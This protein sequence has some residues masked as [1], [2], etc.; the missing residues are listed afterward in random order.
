[1]VNKYY[2]AKLLAISIVMNVANFA[3]SSFVKTFAELNFQAKNS[4]S[5]LRRVI[6]ML[7]LLGSVILVIISTEVYAQSTLPIITIEANI[8]KDRD[9]EGHSYFLIADQKLTEDLTVNYEVV[10]DTGNF[11][12]KEAT[13]RKAHLT[14]NE[15]HTESRINVTESH[16][17]VRLTSGTGYTLGNSISADKID[18]PV[19]TTATEPGIQIKFRQSTVNEGNRATLLARS[20]PAPLRTGNDFLRLDLFFKVDDEDYFN[21][22]TQTPQLFFFERDVVEVGSQTGYN[23]IGEYVELGYLFREN[24]NIMLD[25]TFSARAEAIYTFVNRLSPLR[26][27]KTTSGSDET[28]IR[29][30]DKNKTPLIKIESETAEVNEGGQFPVVISAIRAPI[31]GTEIEVELLANDSDSGFFD[32][33]NAN[34]NRVTLTANEPTRTIMVNTNVVPGL[35]SDGV[36]EVLL[37]ENPSFAIDPEN[38]KVSV[39]VLEIDAVEVSFKLDSLTQTIMEGQVASFTIMSEQ[40]SDI[41]LDINIYID[42]IVSKNFFTWRVP[43]SVRL[44]E[45]EMEAT[46]SIMTGTQ[47]DSG[48]SFSVS[49]GRGFGYR[50]VAPLTAEVTVTADADEIINDE[51]ISVANLAVNNILST[52]NSS[53]S[54][55]QSEATSLPVISVFANLPTVEEGL[56]AEFTL[57]SQP[58]V[59]IQLRIGVSISGTSGLINS[60]TNQTIVLEANQGQKRFSIPTIDNDRAE[61]DNRFVSVSLNPNA[62]YTTGRDSTAEV[63]I[64]DHVD[65]QRRQNRTCSSKPRSF[66]RTIPKYRIFKL[67]E[68]FKSN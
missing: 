24:D 67:G 63:T 14:F 20:T 42:D 65:R 5:Y 27:I 61:D 18:Q 8:F 3:I 13:I 11:A 68:P 58:T 33:F 48:G 29:I 19:E 22:K 47:S 46:F 56:P 7:A 26:S 15:T 35:Q 31:P 38:G 39:N 40:P 16:S 60:E 10:L 37:V 2:R 32:S 44:A 23:F 25:R 6:T 4:A 43:K 12:S 53:P 54:A 1:M 41:N 59:P 49:I 34:N 51:R 9:T 64:T 50:A 28:S 57:I 52:I 45:D 62:S 36:I 17:E 30:L 21:I 55:N 66:I